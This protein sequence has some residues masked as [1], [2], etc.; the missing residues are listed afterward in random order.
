MIEILANESFLM[1]LA[2]NVIA[3]I[4]MNLVYVTGQL[5]LG[6]AGF[7]AVGAYTTAVLDADAGWAL[8]PALA[9]GALVAGAVALPVALGANRVRGIYLIMGTLAVG[10]VV[11]ISIGNFDP[12]GGI[13]GFSGQSGVTLPGVIT[14]L[15]VASVAA[16]LI[17]A[18][19]LGLRMRSIFDDEDAA[20]AAG[21]PT[22]R[23][24]VTAV[25]LSAAMVA[26]AGGL[27]AEFFLFIAPRNFGITISFQIALFTL[28]GGTHSLM[29]AFA[30]AFGVTYLLEVLRKIDDIEWIPSTFSVLSGWRFVVYGAL[31]MV[32]MAVLPEGLVSRGS[33]LRVTA[34]LRRSSRRWWSLLTPSRPGSSIP[35]NGEAILQLRGISHRFGGLVALNEVSFDVKRGEIVALIGAN[36]AG[37]TTL[38]NVV[39]GHHRC[40][41]GTILLNGEDITSWPAHLRARGGVA[42]TF[43]SVRVLSHITVEESVRLGTFACNGR[44]RPS[45]DEILGSIGLLDSARRLPDRLSLADQ[46]RLEMGRALASSPLLILLDEPS[47]GMNEDERAELADLIRRV[48]NTGTTVVVV[49]HNLDLALGVAD[50]VVVLDFGRVLTSDVPEAILRDPRVREAYLGRTYTIP[51]K[52]TAAT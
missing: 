17:M 34:P 50:R 14:T 51:G 24:K 47:V 11:R 29:G 43:Q 20:S 37:K 49:D 22:K 25:V 21:V 4:G 9:A 23:V 15:V 36:G 2:I 48:R 52:G 7:L 42:R 6:Q 31:V 8:A 18:S 38:I 46:R 40:Q 44:P 1:L 19:P 12:V 5:N 41:Q 16:N 39:T 27:L 32:V 3:A 30:G 10:E 45:V 35:Q 26:I 28:I 13:Q 33:A